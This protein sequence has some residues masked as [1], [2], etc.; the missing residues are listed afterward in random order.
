MSTRPTASAPANVSSGGR[1]P[2]HGPAG[3]GARLTPAHPS[4]L[5]TN[6]GN[7]DGAPCVFPFIF[8]GTSYDTCTTDGRSDGYRW[9]ATTANFDQ[10]KKYGFCP[11]RGACGVGAQGACR[12]ARAPAVLRG[13]HLRG[14]GQPL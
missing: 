14:W 13:G 7:S 5:Y 2:L 12:A 11:N 10:D 1:Q 3:P 6:G 8:D 9:C 4:V